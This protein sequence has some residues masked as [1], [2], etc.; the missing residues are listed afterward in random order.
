MTTGFI[1][2]LTKA[3]KEVM[4][5]SIYKNFQVSGRPKWEPLSE[6]T[7]R[8]RDYY[9]HNTSAP[10]VWTGKL[11]ETASS[12]E[13][14]KITKG[15]ATIDDLPGDVWYGKIHQAGYD[16]GSMKGRLKKFGGDPKKALESLMDEQ[17]TKM[18]T[19]G[20]MSGGGASAI[21]AR[22]FVVFQPEDEDDISQIFIDW[23]EKQFDKH[24]PKGV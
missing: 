13:V 7:L 12:F 19:G 18:Q 17:V 24:W 1:E 14:W 23:M 6:A 8:I 15:F 2:P 4:M 16:G 22:P 10:L 5:P 20:K 21:P 11:W 3:V 9:G